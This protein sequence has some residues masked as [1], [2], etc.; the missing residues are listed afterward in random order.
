M[1]GAP[2]Q[3]VE[4]DPLAC[5]TCH[6]DRYNEATLQI[7]WREKTVAEVLRLSVDEACAFFSNEASV[8]RPLALLQ[9]IGLGYLRL[10]QPATELSG[11]E[12][13]RIKLATELQRP[14]RGDALYILDEPTTG[15][16]PR[17]VDQLMVQLQGLVDAGNTVI[18]VEHEMRVIAGSDWVVDVGPGAGDQGG[19]IVAAGPPRDVAG[20]PDSRTAPYLQRFLG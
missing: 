11:G 4:V 6:G 17:D 7:N 3:I 16:H 8:M 12:A 5:P 19:R 1:G 9:Q 18:V 2:A 10:G 20:C 13:Q 14:Q 15:L